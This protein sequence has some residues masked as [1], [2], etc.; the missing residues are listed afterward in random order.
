MP[1]ENESPKLVSVVIA[2]YNAQPFL[3]D[4]LNSLFS[5]PGDFEIV[6]VDN[7]STD[8]SSA[9]VKAVFGRQDKLKLISLPQNVGSALARNIGAAHSSSQYLFFLDSDTV[10]KNGWLNEITRFFAQHPAA[11]LAQVKLLKMGT[12]NFDSAGDLFSPFGFLVERA[13]GA[14]DDGQFDRIEAIFSLKTA[15]A[16]MRR[17]VFQKIRGFDE[18]YYIF[19]E[20]TDLAWRTWLAGRP[21]LFCPQIT[22]EHAFGTSQKTSRY[23]QERQRA[24]QITHLG[25]RNQLLTLLK[26]LGAARLI[27]VLPAV[28]LSWLILAVLFFS[29]REPKKTL[30]IFQAFFWNLK[31]LRPTLAKRTRIQAERKINDDELFAAIG[32]NPGLLYYFGKAFAYIRNKPF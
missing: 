11:G 18:D 19:W 20:D 7:G 15:G 31:N 21:V 4:C 8:Q 32:K 27:L 9:S 24:Y 6:W 30:A 26:N 13:R 23:Y 28:S 22:V 10:V 29:C 12:N 2:A 16:V 25:C 17:D 3:V 1:D 14:R 5:E